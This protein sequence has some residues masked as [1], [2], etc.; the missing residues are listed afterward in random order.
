[1]LMDMD[2][3]V[4]QCQVPCASFTHCHN[5]VESIVY[6]VSL[7]SVCV[8]NASFV[9]YTYHFI[10]M[11]Y[12]IIITSLSALP[13]LSSTDS[14]FIGHLKPCYIC[15][16]YIMLLLQFHPNITA[17]SEYFITYHSIQM[18][19]LNLMVPFM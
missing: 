10:T 14:C 11:T 9:L 19:R 18:Y 6:V 5:Y 3:T 1:M 12:F 7:I 16:L 13:I 8:Y 2:V 4:E 15:T 17:V